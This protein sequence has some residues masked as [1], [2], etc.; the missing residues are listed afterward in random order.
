MAKNTKERIIYAIINLSLILII[1]SLTLFIYFVLK[2]DKEEI[3]NEYE[4]NVNTIFSTLEAQTNNIVTETLT[5]NKETLVIPVEEIP[6]YNNEEYDF[7]KINNNRYYYNQ[8]DDT[9]KLIYDS[10]EKNLNNMKSGNYQIKLPNTVSDVLKNGSGEE[11]LQQS[12]QSAWDALSLDRTDIFFIDISK[13]TL[14]IK[15]TTYINKTS[16]SLIIIP[17]DENGYL[18]DGIE[19]KDMVEQMLNKTKNSRDEI[20]N[21][22]SGDTYNKVLQIHDWI[23]ENLEYSS[24]FQ[25]ANVYN[26][27]GALIEKNAV[28]EG[29]AESF[30]YMLDELGIPCILV[31]GTATNSEGVTENHEWNYVKLE[32]KWY[33]VDV[34]W[35]DPISKGLGYI[36]NKEKHRYFLQGSETMNKK[37]IPKGKITEAGQEFVY[38]ELEASE[39]KR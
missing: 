30:K 11:V 29:Y 32:E 20:I 21:S 22:I 25:N 3:F 12:F 13:I 26:T 38:P 19:N 36:T 34:T 39:Y 4:N 31:K 15:K 37:H 6:I 10:I 35:D 2:N 24:D 18:E 1:A 8:L 33:A 14:R 16:Y 7:T 28:C 5:E 17:E 27:Y 23:I 9:A